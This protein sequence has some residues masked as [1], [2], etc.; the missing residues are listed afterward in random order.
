M[1]GSAARP[2]QAAAPTPMA[3][4]TTI[5][6]TAAP[7][8]SDSVTGTAWVICGM[9]FTPRFTKEVRSRCTNR[10]SI[11]R[12]YRTGS[13]R[14]RPNSCR[15]CSRVAWSA[16]RP[17]MRAAG[18]TPG[19]AKKMRNTITLSENSTRAA[20]AER[21]TAKLSISRPPATGRADR[22]P[23]ARRHRAG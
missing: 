20:E 3:M 23:H 22:G 6:M 7:I 17:A 1:M 18:S 8:T 11:I 5:Q 10:C 12:P 9:T 14:S 13:G 15:T 21:L 19:V 16:L 4:P 2:C